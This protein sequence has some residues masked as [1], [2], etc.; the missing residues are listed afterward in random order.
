MGKWYLFEDFCRLV[1]G[2]VS[3]S[4]AIKFYKVEGKEIYFEDDEIRELKDTYIEIMNQSNPPLAYIA[5]VLSAI[6]PGKLGK[7]LVRVP[8]PASVKFITD[9]I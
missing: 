9:E 7:K 4:T 3:K 2:R 8:R 5:R 6:I 1:Y